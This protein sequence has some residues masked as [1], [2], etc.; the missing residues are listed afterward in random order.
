VVGQHRG[1]WL[2]GLERVGKGAAT[3]GQHIG[4]VST[5]GGG[6]QGR[7]W[8]GQP[9]ETTSSRSSPIHMEKTKQ[10]GEGGRSS[11]AGEVDGGSRRE[12]QAAGS[13]R[14]EHCFLLFSTEPSANNNVWMVDV[15]DSQ[16][17]LIRVRT[18][19]WWLLDVMSA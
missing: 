14:R 9:P 15:G 10:G 12:G 8:W 18:G 4:E 5:G 16:P 2:E 1:K 13:R 11:D 17:M 6:G 7:R 19:G 3:G